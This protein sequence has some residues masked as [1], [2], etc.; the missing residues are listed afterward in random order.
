MNGWNGLLLR[1]EWPIVVTAGMAYCCY[2][3]NS[4]LLLRLEWPVVVEA[5]MAC[6]CYGVVVEAEWPVVEAGMACC[7]R[8]LEWPVVGSCV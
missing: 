6:Y 1:L 7:C 8:R 4:L 5:G 2:G 3:W